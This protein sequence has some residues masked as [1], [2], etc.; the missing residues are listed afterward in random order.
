LRH[1]FRKDHARQ[2]LDDVRPG[3]IHRGKRRWQ[4]ELIVEQEP[5][6]RDHAVAPRRRHQ[7]TVG[8]HDAVDADLAG[9]KG[10][11]GAILTQ[12]RDQVDM[13]GRH[14][15]TS[16]DGPHQRPQV[17]GWRS[18]EEDRGHARRKSAREVLGTPDHGDHG[19]SLKRFE[20]AAGRSIHGQRP[21]GR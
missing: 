7:L 2:N 6:D 5:L 8:G 4:A 17:K 10:D 21:G 3:A 18:Q 9:K 13:D 19:D 1:D 15:A 20:E 14:F 11:A 16:L 12:A